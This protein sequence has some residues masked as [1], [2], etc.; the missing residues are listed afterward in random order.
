MR[1]KRIEGANSG[2]ELTA[3]NEERLD[4][5]GLLPAQSYPT[6]STD[7]SPLLGDDLES[8][9]LAFIRRQSGE[10]LKSSRCSSG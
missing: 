7:T 10:K 3:V 1:S 9:G 5:A 6:E 4:S 2:F 8:T